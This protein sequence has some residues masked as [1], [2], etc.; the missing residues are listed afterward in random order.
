[1]AKRLRDEA[2]FNLDDLAANAEAFWL[3]STRGAAARAAREFAPGPDRI[4][5]HSEGAAMRAARE[6]L[7]DSRT[8]AS[9]HPPSMQELRRRRLQADAMPVEEAADARE[10]TGDD[11][12]ELR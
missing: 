6:V 3:D 7:E 9:P 5:G 10:R 12:W 1:V 11:D 4:Q 8:F 2:P